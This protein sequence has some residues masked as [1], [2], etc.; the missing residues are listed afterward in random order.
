MISKASTL[1]PILKISFLLLVVIA[2]IPACDSVPALVP[3]GTTDEVASQPEPTQIEAEAPPEIL[4]TGAVRQWAISAEAS[5][6]YDN[7]EWAAV[8]ATGAP[9]TSRCGDIQTAWASA[10]SDDIDWLELEYDNPV[11]VSAVNIYQTFN[12]NQVTKVELVS[13]FGNSVTIYEADPI[14]VDQPCPYILSIVIDK[15]NTRYNKV[16]LTVD[17]SSMG[18]GWNEID[19]VELVGDAERTE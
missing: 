16:R 10:G 13:S 4:Q 6:N 18:L 17:Q 1:I 19:A 12:P 8:Q 11:Y 7:P 3:S 2:G 14:Q 15:T 9:N 5:S